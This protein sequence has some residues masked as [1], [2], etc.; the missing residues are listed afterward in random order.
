[1][2]F[3]YL[4]HLECRFVIWQATFEV[5]FHRHPQLVSRPNHQFPLPTSWPP[6]RTEFALM[7]VTIYHRKWRVI[8]NVNFEHESNWQTIL[9]V[10]CSAYYR[11]FANWSTVAK[12]ISLIVWTYGIGNCFHLLGISI[13][14]GI[15]F[16]MIW[17]I[18]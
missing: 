6:Q 8:I 2:N 10:F 4:R 9:S 1:M 14:Y 7:E 3:Q 11:L 12:C 5:I 18:I 15:I 13:I 16:S 17:V